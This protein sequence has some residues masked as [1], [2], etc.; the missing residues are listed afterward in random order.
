MSEKENW[1]FRS[2]V[3]HTFSSMQKA[4]CKINNSDGVVILKNG[5]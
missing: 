2:C 5:R 4:I 1:V 3:I